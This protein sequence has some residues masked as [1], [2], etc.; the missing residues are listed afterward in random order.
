MTITLEALISN[1]GNTP[2]TDTVSVRFYDITGPSSVQIGSDQVITGLTGCA[3]EL[4][5]VSVEWPNVTP[6]V[7]QVRVEVDPMGLVPEQ[8]EVNNVVEGVVLVATD[9]VFV[10]AGL[11][12]D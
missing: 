1:A 7:H 5:R 9:R 3:M 11:R 8:S 4:A 12:W 2:F 6:G 10:P